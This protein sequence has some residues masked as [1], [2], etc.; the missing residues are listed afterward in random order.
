MC[1]TMFL[2]ALPQN[3]FCLEESLPSSSAWWRHNDHE[4]PSPA[5]MAA[6]TGHAH[7]QAGTSYLAFGWVFF[8]AASLAFT[9]SGSFAGMGEF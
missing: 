1:F 2:L 4:A 5:T 8:A 3:S 6:G 7:T 9:G